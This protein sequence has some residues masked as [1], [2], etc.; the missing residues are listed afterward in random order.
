LRTIGPYD[1]A[2]GAKEANSIAKGANELAGDANTIAE[3]ALRAA[4]DD[5]PYNWVLKVDDNGAWIINDCGHVDDDGKERAKGFRTKAE[6]KAWLDTI[7][8]SRITGTYVDPVLGSVTFAS[9][10]EDWAPRQVWESGTRHA[11]DQAARSVTFGD[12]ALSELR[13]SHLETWVR[14]MQE[15]KLEPSTIRTR[16]SN[17]RSVI[18]SALRDCLMARDVTDRIRLPGS[19]RLRP[20]CRFLPLTRWCGAAERQRVVRGLRGDLRVRRS[21][22]R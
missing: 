5:I 7:V 1:D 12:V 19:A 17:A 10:Y 2:F 9:Y 8:S 13:P 6:A 21:A 3:R 15:R 11:M 18:R 16:F 22:S 20:P 4:Q 14:E